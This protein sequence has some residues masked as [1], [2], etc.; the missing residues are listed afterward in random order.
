MR[1]LF[2]ADIEGVAGVASL[3]QLGPKE[4]E[5][6]PARTWMTN[7]V[8]SAANAALASGYDEVLIADG[9]GNASEHPA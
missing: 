2:I 1:K 5:W 7:E 4:I 6:G 3:D 8:A 9:H